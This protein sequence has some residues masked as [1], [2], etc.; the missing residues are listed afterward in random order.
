LVL[1]TKKRIIHYLIPSSKIGTIVVNFGDW[2]QLGFDRGQL[3][4]QS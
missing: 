4:K 1:L 3:Q 2:P